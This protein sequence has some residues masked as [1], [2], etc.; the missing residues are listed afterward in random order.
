MLNSL[1]IY[2]FRNHYNIN[3]NSF[4]PI[5]K[6]IALRN[7]MD[8]I[9]V[10]VEACMWKCMQG[11]PECPSTPSHPVKPPISF[12]AQ[13]KF[14]HLQEA[15]PPF[16]PSGKPP[17]LTFHDM[18]LIIYSASFYLDSFG[19]IYPLIHYKLLRTELSIL[20]GLENTKCSVK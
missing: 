1:H 5:S 12:K 17:S 19:F 14:H 11:N 16:H 9:F 2:H 7:D 10:L 4:F 18:V 13:L 15:W 20:E 3:W 8:W 6:S